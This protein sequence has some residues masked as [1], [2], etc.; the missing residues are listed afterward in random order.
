MRE[1]TLKHNTSVT[2]LRDLVNLS[3][4]DVNGPLAGQAVSVT[5]AE[6]MKS[7]LSRELY[8]VV[9]SWFT[10]PRLKY[11]KLCQASCL[12]SASYI[13]R[14]HIQELTAEFL[15]VRCFHLKMWTWSNPEVMIWKLA[16]WNI[17]PT[18]TYPVLLL[19]VIR[20]AL[21][22]FI[23][24]TRWSQLSPLNAGKCTCSTERLCIL[25]E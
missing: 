7:S 24:L 12:I 3:V 8:T 5:A 9:M 6:G 14:R 19:C 21:Y 25:W 13:I 10:S 22:K 4:L 17:P 11:F 23:V 20:T 2:S 16:L 18:L 1:V 15:C